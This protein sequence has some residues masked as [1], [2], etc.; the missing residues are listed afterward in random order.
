MPGVI[1]F[2]TDSQGMAYLTPADM[3]LDQLQALAANL[4]EQRERARTQERF[5][6]NMLDKATAEIKYRCDL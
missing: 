3:D 2:Y 6:Q 4:A 5:F 1:P